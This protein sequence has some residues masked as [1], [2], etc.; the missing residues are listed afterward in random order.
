MLADRVHLRHGAHD[1][2]GEIVRVGTGEAHSANAGHGSHR[3]EQ[4]R[5]I[6]FPVVVRVHGLAQQHDL[7]HALRG[8]GLDLADDVRQAPA[9]LG[10]PRHRH[11][12]VRAPVVAPALDGNPGLHPVESAWR[13]VLVML[14]EVEAGLDRPLTGAGPFQERRQRPIAVGTDH[15]TD[16]PRLLQ[17][18][19]AE[20]L[21]HAPRHAH[22]GRRLHHALE[23]PEAAEHPLLG[24]IADRAG[25]E[26][27]DVRLVRRRRLG[28]SARRQ[29]AE[30]EL[31]IAEVHLAAVRL[32]V[33]AALGGGSSHGV[34]QEWQ[35]A[36]R[37]RAQAAPGPGSPAGAGPRQRRPEDS[38]P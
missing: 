29:P 14:L 11:D 25:V 9:P 33:H 10:A 32:D 8:Q 20:A 37:R 30:H 4:R 34:R 24:V 26:Q 3:A 36:G 2:V 1:R 35:R 7:R 31:G 19:C 38:P 18:R 12:A 27:D 22:R 23:L 15:E 17:Q 21:R 13:E 28:V 6:R 5:E 16:V